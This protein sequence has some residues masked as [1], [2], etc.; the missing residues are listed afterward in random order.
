MK[1]HE[2]PVFLIHCGLNWLDTPEGANAKYVEGAMD[3]IAH[4]AAR[5]LAQELDEAVPISDMRDILCPN[6]SVKEIKS[7]FVKYTDSLKKDKVYTVAV[8]RTSV[9]ERYFRVR[10]SCG[11]QAE[12]IAVDMAYDV[13][14]NEDPE[15]DYEYEIHDTKI[16]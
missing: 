6:M 9:R 2:D 15:V 13:D 5:Y 14:F 1:K 16:E 4:I 8:R 3:G 12:N 7:A 11:K 10:A